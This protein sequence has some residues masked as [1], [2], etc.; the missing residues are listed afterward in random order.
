M[1]ANEY[2]MKFEQGDIIQSGALNDY[3]PIPF[4]VLEVDEDRGYLLAPRTEQETEMEF[5]AWFPQEP[6][7]GNEYVKV[8]TTVLEEDD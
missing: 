4:E 6:Y 5:P 2:D 1:T 3:A 7:I 8:G